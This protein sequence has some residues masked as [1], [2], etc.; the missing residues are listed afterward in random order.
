MKGVNDTN[1]DKSFKSKKEIKGIEDHN[2]KSKEIIFSTSKSTKLSPN[3]SFVMSNHNEFLASNS[4]LNYFK[5]RCDELNQELI[6]KQSELQ[7]LYDTLNNR[8]NTIQNLMNKIGFSNEIKS[9][10]EN[11]T[12]EVGNLKKTIQELQIINANLN[13]SLQSKDKRI[14]EFDEVVNLAKRKFSVFESNNE[15]KF[16]IY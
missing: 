11:K 12:L 10:H 5:S 1:E 13:L 16:Y 4:E 14:N 7:I 2:E 9:K 15:C 3:L 6:R 8:E